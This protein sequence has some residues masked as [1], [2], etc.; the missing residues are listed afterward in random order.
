MIAQHDYH[1]PQ[2]V[3][4]D[5][6]MDDL[7]LQKQQLSN[8]IT[9]NRC[10]ISLFRSG[11]FSSAVLN[12]KSACKL[13]KLALKQQGCW[14]EVDCLLDTITGNDKYTDNSPLGMNGGASAGDFIFLQPIDIPELSKP[15]TNQCKYLI[16]STVMFNL[17]LTLHQMAMACS[18]L[19]SR[20]RLLRK[21]STL[22][23]YA[24]GLQWNVDG[25]SSI[26]NL[27]CMATLNNLGQVYKSLG[28]DGKA[29]YFFSHLLSTLLLL[30]QQD[31]GIL[32][33]YHGYT[34]QFIQTTSFLTSPSSDGTI[35]TLGSAAAA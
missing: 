18:G 21:A 7:V 6:C 35:K 8:A 34:L 4:F 10:A 1:K 29:R 17:A 25:V 2:V 3:P 13:S 16:T 9:F 23:E 22:Y 32:E 11:R 24:Y 15:P 12:L 30:Q 19:S 5:N 14:E 31:N 27:F 28:D 26:K 33:K 20:A